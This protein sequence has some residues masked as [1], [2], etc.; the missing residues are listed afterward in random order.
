MTGGR[1]AVGLAEVFSL[2]TYRSSSGQ[3]H[4]RSYFFDTPAEYPWARDAAGLMP[5]SISRLVKLVIELC[6]H[7][8][9]VP[10]HLT[11]AGA[12]FVEG[13]AA[14]LGPHP[15]LRPFGEPPVSCRL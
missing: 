7:Y 13:Q 14:E 4:E 8:D 3:A 9:I 2:H 15:G 12:E 10:W 1:D 11:P 6:E 5:S